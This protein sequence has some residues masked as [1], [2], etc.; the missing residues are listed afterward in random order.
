MAF[1]VKEVA[2]EILCEAIGLCGDITIYIHE[3]N[4]HQFPRPSC[5]AIINEEYCTDRTTGRILRYNEFALYMKTYDGIV[6]CNEWLMRMAERTTESHHF[7][8]VSLLIY[9]TVL[10]DFST[11]AIIDKFDMPFGE[12]SSLYNLGGIVK[13]ADRYDDFHKSIRC[14]KIQDAFRRY[15]SKRHKAASVIQKKWRHVISDPS[16][17]PC[18]KRIT[19]EFVGLGCVEQ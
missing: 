11:N 1:Y 13:L 14:R 2:R 9:R 5:V 12:T 18:K 10:N 4:E 16:C 8:L 6:E 7:S 17:R 3:D 15:N 19:W